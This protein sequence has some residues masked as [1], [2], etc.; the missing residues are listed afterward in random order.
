MNI[1]V[2]IF[3]DQAIDKL[4]LIPSVLEFV[5]ILF[6]SVST[7][8][9][10]AHVDSLLVKKDMIIH[11]VLKSLLEQCE[12]TRNLKNLDIFSCP[13][14]LKKNSLVSNFFHFLG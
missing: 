4:P 12:E 5:G 2:Y 14:M 7:V 9:N 11:S 8:T 10:F 13:I 1:L 6:S 3:F